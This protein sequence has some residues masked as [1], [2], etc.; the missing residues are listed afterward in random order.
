MDAICDV[1]MHLPPGCLHSWIA[2]L[3]IGPARVRLAG[4]PPEEL[5]PTLAEAAVLLYTKVFENHLAP[6]SSNS[7]FFV[8]LGGLTPSGFHPSYSKSRVLL[9]KLGFNTL[10]FRKSH[11]MWAILLKTPS[12]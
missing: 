7:Y 3:K 8:R 6:T 5:H 11:V 12:T 4:P 2:P 1:G 10:N 9:Y